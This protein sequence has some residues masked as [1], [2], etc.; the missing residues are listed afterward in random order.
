[1]FL[2][3]CSDCVCRKTA[4]ELSMIPTKPLPQFTEEKPACCRNPRTPSSKKSNRIRSQGQAGTLQQAQKP[5]DQAWPGAVAYRIACRSAGRRRRKR[6]CPP[7]LETGG[8]RVFHFSAL[9]PASQAGRHRCSWVDIN[10]DAAR[11]RPTGSGRAGCPGCCP[12]AGRC[13]ARR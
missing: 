6:R 9:R 5:T 8:H 4:I 2:S 13:S 3:L 7:V 11:S 1:M 10:A 12:P